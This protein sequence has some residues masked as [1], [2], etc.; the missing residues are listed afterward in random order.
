MK[1][2][3][4]VRWALHP[5]TAVVRV[6]DAFDNSQTK[7][8]PALL[9]LAFAPVEQIKKMG[10]VQG[11]DTRPLVRDHKFH[12][13]SGLLNL[14]GY[15]GVRRR[16]FNGVFHQIAQSPLKQDGIG[17]QNDNVLGKFRGQRHIL[18]PQP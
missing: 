10:Q 7:T 1:D 13:R 4:L 6:D 11:V 15:P 12:F 9:P 8:Q 14:Q 18:R 16:I 5:Q 3:T 17:L 2:R